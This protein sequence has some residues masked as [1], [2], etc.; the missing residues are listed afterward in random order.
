MPRAIKPHSFLAPPV[1][2]TDV[3]VDNTGSLWQP[4]PGN[5]TVV[6]GAYKTLADH[7]L[8]LLKTPQSKLV[9]E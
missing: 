2:S 3:E 1:S 8:D 9:G 7:T 6:R 5:V 4:V